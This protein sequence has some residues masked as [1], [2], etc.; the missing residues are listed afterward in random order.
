M[1][2]GGRLNLN[3][4]PHS[5]IKEIIQKKVHLLMTKENY[6]FSKKWLLIKNKLPS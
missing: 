5:V 3:T 6:T 2:L 4:F 1:F